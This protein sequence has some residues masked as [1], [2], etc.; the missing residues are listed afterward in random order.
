M[1]KK[2]SLLAVVIVGIM[3]T[4]VLS[5][6]LAAQGLQPFSIPAFTAAELEQV[7]KEGEE[8]TGDV[9]VGKKGRLVQGDNVYAEA[10]GMA[11]TQK[12]FSLKC[13]QEVGVPCSRLG[14]GYWDDLSGYGRYALRFNGLIEPNQSVDGLWI[15][16]DTI[17]RKQKNGSLN[18]P[19]DSKNG[20]RRHIIAFLHSRVAAMEERVSNLGKGTAQTNDSA[21]AE[22][23]KE[24]ED[25]MK[26]LPDEF[27][28]RDEFSSSKGVVDQ[29][30]ADLSVS[31][32]SFANQAGNTVVAQ[33]VGMT[34]KERAAVG[35]VALA[36]LFLILLVLYRSW[37]AD[38]DLQKQIGFLNTKVERLV[39]VT[40]NVTFDEVYLQHVLDIVRTGLA[41]DF[42]VLHKST[43]ESR[44]LRLV[45]MEA[46]LVEIQGLL[47][48]PLRMASLR[49]VPLEYERVAREIFRAGNT[50]RIKG[51]SDGQTRQPF[52]DDPVDSA[53]A[54]LQGDTEVV[55]EVDDDRRVAA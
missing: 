55:K 37:G 25:A 35:V 34:P 3:V 49:P 27:V 40:S 26:K 6:T 22:R 47:A 31:P 45:P 23:L 12:A 5:T 16:L 28:G 1:S 29:R 9:G 33:A 15:P 53:L 13:A 46:G 2:N 43:G 39:D 18:V 11:I 44:K 32:L 41:Q 38:G 54:G 7:F 21:V 4:T 51:L 20:D 8:I 52:Q 30:F 17:R 48:H 24:I 14:A 42:P 36:L 10:F 50:G 19:V